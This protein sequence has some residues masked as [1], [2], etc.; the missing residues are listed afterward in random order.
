MEHSKGNEVIEFVRFG[1]GMRLGGTAEDGAI[2]FRD[3]VYIWRILG[4]DIPIP[5]HLLFGRAHVEERPV[6]EHEFSMQMQLRHPWF[7]DV[8]RY[9]GRFSMPA[10]A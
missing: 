5:V 4:K 10:V 2:V 1:V 3:Q 9:N 6:N 8:F 7:G